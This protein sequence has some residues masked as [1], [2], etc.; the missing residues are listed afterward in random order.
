MATKNSKH[1]ITEI[2]RQ[3]DRVIDGSVVTENTMHEVTDDDTKPVTGKA[4]KNYVAKEVKEG[5]ERPVSGAAVFGEIELAKNPVELGKF[6]YSHRV[7]GQWQQGSLLSGDETPN[8]ARVRT[9]F[10]S[11]KGVVTLP[12]GFI[13]RLVAYYD[14]E[15]N[16]IESVQI[17]ASSAVVGRNECVYRVIAQRYDANANVLPEEMYPQDECDSVVLINKMLGAGNQSPIPIDVIIGKKG[18]AI[19]GNGDEYSAKNYGITAPIHLAAGETIVYTLYAGEV[20]EIAIPR[21][22]GYDVINYAPADGNYWHTGIYTAPCDMDVVLC[23]LISRL[24]FAIVAT[25]YPPSAV[26]VDVEPQRGSNRGIASSY[27]HHL[28]KVLSTQMGVD[29]R[30]KYQ[31][32]SGYVLVSSE[33]VVSST[34]Y[35]VTEPISVSRGD[36]IK[37]RAACYTDTAALAFSTDKDSDIWTPKVVG[38][39][40]TESNLYSYEME[41]D[42]YIRLS[43]NNAM[44]FE[45]IIERG[46]RLSLNGGI[47]LSNTLRGRRYSAMRDFGTQ[48]AANGSDGAFMNIADDYN[49]LIN[50]VYE[51]LRN[52]NPNYISRYSAGRDA[53]DTYEQ[54]VYTFEPKF[55]EQSILLVAGVHANEEDAIAGLARIMQMITDEYERDDDLTYIRQN[56]KITVVPVVNVW[57]YSQ[58][59][60]MRTNANEES[61]QQWNAEIPPVE[62]SN[63]KTIFERLK[64]ELAFA[65]DL[66]TTTNNSYGD[67]Y[68]V[69]NKS[70]A[71]NRTL[72]RTHAWLTE[73]YGQNKNVDEQLIGYLKSNVVLSYYLANELGIPSATL[74]LSDYHW[75]SK[76]GTSK[77]Q[78]MAITMWLNYIIQ[79][80]NDNYLPIELIPEKSYKIVK[81]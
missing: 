80:I 58:S 30:T 26:P 61:I 69:I 15:L 27:A 31:S 7:L 45:M 34:E 13:I 32:K 56:V 22:E 38:L 67:F 78:T 52:A 16:F 64:D 5:D 25:V 55:Y 70:A 75:D 20:S 46:N 44:P 37:W 68:C 48:P 49:T 19:G 40:N 12:E 72:Y 60:K 36:V 63:M 57:G 9:A 54:W 8:S 74:E 28:S 42:G 24:E 21:D 66:H 4:L 10:L 79:Q 41:E 50:E 6:N 59:P 29:S 2:D 33:A 81:G 73:T 71:N 23:G 14:T 11:W 47:R 51:P 65:A 62:V 43:Y 3:I 18:A 1:T 76:K 17:N 53:T 77:V 39:R 35:S